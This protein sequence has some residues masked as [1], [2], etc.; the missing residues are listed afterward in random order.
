MSEKK[1]NPMR[2]LE[3]AIGYLFRT[4]HQM[5]RESINQ[6]TRTESQSIRLAKDPQACKKGKRANQG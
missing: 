1:E 4:L 2:K 5:E 3:E 6:R